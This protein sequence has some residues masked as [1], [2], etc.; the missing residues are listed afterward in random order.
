MSRAL[1]RARASHL[2][3]DATYHSLQDL[4]P[5]V[6]NQSIDRSI[7]RVVFD[8]EMQARQVVVPEMTTDD[9][10]FNKIQYEIVLSLKTSGK[11]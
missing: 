8:S 2:V 5:G 9:P 11:L 3:H 6:H 10:G 4:T 7:D 1:A